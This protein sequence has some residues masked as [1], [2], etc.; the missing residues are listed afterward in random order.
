MFS[1]ETNTPKMELDEESKTEGQSPELDDE[2]RD[3]I[4][5]MGKLYSVLGSE[6]IDLGELENITL[7]WVMLKIARFTM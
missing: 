5:R 2:D 7:R 1:T 3:T 4:R 6:K